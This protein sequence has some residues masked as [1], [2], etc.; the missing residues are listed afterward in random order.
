[1]ISK[2]TKEMTSFIVMDVLEK[3]GEMKRQGTHIIHL[4]SYANS[5]ENIAEGMERTGKYLS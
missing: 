4:F 2:R 3:A 1:M 5:M